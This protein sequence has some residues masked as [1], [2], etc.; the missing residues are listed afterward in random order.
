MLCR[1]YFDEMQMWDAVRL[2]AEGME[3]EFIQLF[4]Y[5]CSKAPMAA[6]PGRQHVDPVE[7][8]PRLLPHLILLDVERPPAGLR[9]RFRVASTSFTE[10]VGREGTGLCFDELG[11][12]DRVEPVCSALSTVVTTGRPVFLAGRLTLLSR[13]YCRVKRLA[14]P[15]ARDGHQVDMIIAVFLLER[16]PPSADPDIESPHQQQLVVL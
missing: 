12:A 1:G 13:D 4:D 9:F 3:P 10:L 7:L 5:W 2:P 16:H 14:L 8:P 15:L 11:A 6:L